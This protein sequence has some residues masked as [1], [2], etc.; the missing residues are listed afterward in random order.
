[1]ERTTTLR[2]KFWSAMAIGALASVSMLL[3]TPAAAD[4]S[5]VVI[6]HIPPGNPGNAQTITVGEKAVAAHMKHG[7][8]LGQCASGC[9]SA[10]DCEDENLCTDDECLSNGECSHTAV[11]CDDSNACTEDLCEPLEGCLYPPVSAPTVCDDQDVCTTGDICQEGVCVGTDVFGCCNFASE[12]DDGDWCTTD[13]CEGNVCAHED[14]DCS[15]SDPC[16]VGFCD[17]LGAMCD[18]A[19]VSCEDA[20]VCTDDLC[21]S[22]TGCYNPPTTNPPEPGI[23]LTCDDGLDNDCD[24]AADADDADCAPSCVPTDEICDGV[25]NDCDGDVD[26]DFDLGVCTSGIGA[27]QATGTMVCTADGTASECSA[28]PGTPSDEI[29]DGQDNDCDGTVDETPAVGYS[30]NGG[31]IRDE[32][33]LGCAE[34]FVVEDTGLVCDDQVGQTTLACERDPEGMLHATYS[35]VGCGAPVTVDVE[36]SQGC[37]VLDSSTAPGVDFIWFESFQCC[38]LPPRSCSVDNGRCG[39]ARVFECAPDE[40]TEVTCELITGYLYGAYLTG[41]QLYGADLHGVDLTHA[42]LTNADLYNANL[43]NA[44][45]DYA[46]LNG[47]DI[48]L[49]NFS[50]ASLRGVNVPTAVYTNFD[51]AD[52][53]GADL[54]WVYVAGSTFMYANL[55]GADL[56]NV[57]LA[58]AAWQGAT[59]TSATLF[60]AG[61]NPAAYGMI[62]VP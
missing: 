53:S 35:R 19:P 44:T 12:C 31:I 24:G 47:A 34:T 29:C 33:P 45:L 57:A 9:L 58:S 4:N 30:Y 22:E 11:D 51:G 1:M 16:W 17:S 6:C 32:T 23:E 13:S 38:D 52:L 7:D 62:L 39:D 5:K 60:S 56:R 2:R 21:D 10:A 59:Y 8:W 18:Y 36:A 20:D 55:D 42:D 15:T 14:T 3:A 43:S 49:T 54:N 37:A 26:E 28:V 27:C 25:D 50:D 46:N 48:N 41:A 61:V 40:I